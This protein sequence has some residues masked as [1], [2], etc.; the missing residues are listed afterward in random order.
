MR[1]TD[2]R[3]SHGAPVGAARSR[4]LLARLTGYE[5]VRGRADAR[6]I[7]RLRAEIG[8]T[9]DEARRLY[10]LAR[11]HG[12]GAAYEL[13]FGAPP[14]HPRRRPIIGPAARKARPPHGLR[15]QRGHRAQP[16]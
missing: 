13:V 3:A 6:N 9:P 15:S 11:E 10:F 4:S 2:Q 16:S 14:R 12:F 1:R 7:D 5:L 8:C